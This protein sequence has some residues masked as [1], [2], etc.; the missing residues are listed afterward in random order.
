MVMKV[1]L[2]NFQIGDTVTLQETPMHME[3]TGKVT[4]IYKPETGRPFADDY[5]MVLTMPY[6][7]GYMTCKIYDG[8]KCV[9]IHKEERA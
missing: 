9:D 5:Y 1:N 3:F 4:A 6:G 2:S 8:A 7:S